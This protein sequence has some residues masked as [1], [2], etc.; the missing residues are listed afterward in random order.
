MRTGAPDL[1]DV[2]E[3]IAADVDGL[4][5]SVALAGAQV[6]SVAEARREGVLEPL[7][8]LR[9]RSVVIVYGSTGSASPA[10]QLVTAAVSARIDV[11]IVCAPSLPGWIGPLDVVVLA[12]DDAGDRVLAD[13]A[14]RSVRRRAE[15]VVA[16]PI[17]G[18]LRDAL[19]GSGIDLSPRVSVDPRFRFPGFVAALLAVFVSLT[20]VRFTGR[21]PEVADLADALDGEAGAN[22]PANE[23]FHNHAKSLAARLE[24]RPAVWVGDTPGT[25][26][27]AA[28]AAR[29]LIAVAGTIGAVA[30]IGDVTRI[31]REWS[32]RTGSAPNDSIFHDPEIDGPVG[33]APPRV[34]VVSIPRRELFARRRFDAIG[35]VDVLIGA[36]DDDPVGAPVGRAPEDP[37]GDAPDDLTSLMLLTLRIEMAAV[38]LRLIR[39]Y[40]A[41]Q[42]LR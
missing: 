15:V 5:P 19:G 17:E 28:Q 16:V 4:L 18:P 13:A 3:L 14:A 6:R 10:A 21:I 2:E 26:V 37:S 33:D 22:H 9:P 36:P 42:D 7:T 34:F 39:V 8:H 1:D 40:P 25:S 24:D 35:D 20:Q 29:A 30:E 38:Y 11:P 31:V 12:G 41:D 27:I 32:E 23:S